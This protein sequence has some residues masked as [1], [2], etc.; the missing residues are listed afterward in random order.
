[1]LAKA[2]SIDCVRNTRTDDVARTCQKDSSWSEESSPKVTC[3][4]NTP[5]ISQTTLSAFVWAEVTSRSKAGPCGW[6]PRILLP[7]FYVKSCVTAQEYF[8]DAVAAL[9]VAELNVR[10]Y[11]VVKPNSAALVNQLQGLRLATFTVLT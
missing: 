10:R 5:V 3:T 2:T 8:T 7:W 9:R 6:A 4:V 1:V 11:G